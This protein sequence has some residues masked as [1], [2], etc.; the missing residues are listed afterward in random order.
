MKN[1]IGIVALLLIIIVLM[2]SP[3]LATTHC[4]VSERIVLENTTDISMTHAFTRGSHE[5][6]V[7]VEPGQI[8]TIDLV[9][10]E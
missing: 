7:I 5:G 1:I 2:T 10:C 3:A 6:F 8:I 4:G 9:W